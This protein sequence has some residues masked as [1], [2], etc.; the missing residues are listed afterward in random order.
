M[1]AETL[2]KKPVKL[3]VP[4]EKARFN[5]IY[6]RG[7]RPIPV[8]KKHAEKVLT[9]HNTIILHAMTAAIGKAV[10]LY[11]F[12]MENYPYLKAEIVTDSVPTIN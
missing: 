11:M 12:L 10:Q 4:H 2:T 6:L 1:I 3:P 7:N 9:K 8:Y 5:E